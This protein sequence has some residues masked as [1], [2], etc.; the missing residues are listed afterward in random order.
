MM[1]VQC[2][3]DDAHWMYKRMIFTYNYIC[4]QIQTESERERGG[5]MERARAEVCYKY[6]KYRVTILIHS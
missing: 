6:A 2:T 4:M 5:K 1:Y 3:Q